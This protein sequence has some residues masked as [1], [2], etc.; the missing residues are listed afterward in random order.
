MPIEIDVALEYELTG[1][2]VLLTIEAANLPGQTVLDETLVV[3]GA[4]ITP[5]AGEDGI[6]RRIWVHVQGDLLQLSYRAKVDVTQPKV[7]LEQLP[8]TPISKLPGRVWTYL[9]PSRFCQSDM[10]PG[11]V[12]RRFGA[13]EGGARVAAIRDWVAEEMTYLPGTSTAATTAIDTFAAREGVCRDYAHV[14]CALARAANIP[15][16]YVSVYAPGVEPPDFHAVAQVWLDGDWHIVDATG[17]TEGH[18][19]V[20]IAVGRDACDV[21]FMETESAATLVSQEIAVRRC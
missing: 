20:I 17:M 13:L 21:A 9:R 4:Q 10:F 3:E 19:A 6:G 7:P 8:P 5:I 1:P 2:A 16:R 18:E 11:F 12:S 14:V 15:A